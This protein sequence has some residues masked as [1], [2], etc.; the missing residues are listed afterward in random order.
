MPD[1]RVRLEALRY[2]IAWRSNRLEWAV[3]AFPTEIVL[4]GWSLDVRVTR[5]DARPSDAKLF[6]EGKARAS[7]EPALDAWTAELAVV[8]DLLMTYWFLDAWM[9]P[10]SL[11]GMH[12]YGELSIGDSAH[13]S[14]D[15]TVTR[16]Q[17]ELPAPTWSKPPSSSAQD[18][19]EYCLLPMR[20]GR[21]PEVDAAYWLVE[22]AARWASG[23]DVAAS[24]L[25]VSRG[26]LAQMKK[27]SGRA[28]ERKAAPNTSTLKPGEREMLQR[29]V[30]L[31]VL[32]MHRYEVGDPVGQYI[33]LDTV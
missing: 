33:T 12:G 18:A 1:L 29:M 23:A 10:D 31:V 13:A 17:H 7:L 2:G 4:P 6:D 32:R 28:Y 26:F 27:S 19:R 3:D 11:V 22:H 24:R 20:S 25:N 21:R 16:I 5:I 30:E 9:V 15:V 8:H 14:D